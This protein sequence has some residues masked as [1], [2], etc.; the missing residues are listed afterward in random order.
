ML[1]DKDHKGRLVFIMLCII[2]NNDS[3]I[4]VST[5]GTKGSCKYKKNIK[6]QKK[7]GYNTH[8]HPKK[9][10]SGKSQK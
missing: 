7:F 1:I 4:N 9:K 6:I 2:I 8:P 3:I 5:I 10:M